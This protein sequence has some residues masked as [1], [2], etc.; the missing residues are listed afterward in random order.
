MRL[1]GTTRRPMSVVVLVR[2]RQLATDISEVAAVAM[3]L[4]FQTV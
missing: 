1:S 3:L 4:A 2:S